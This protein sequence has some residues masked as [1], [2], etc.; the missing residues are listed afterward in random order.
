MGGLLAALLL[1]EGFGVAEVLLLPA[2]GLGG[3]A[4]AGSAAEWPGFAAVAGPG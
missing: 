2:E 1:A 4:G 3:L